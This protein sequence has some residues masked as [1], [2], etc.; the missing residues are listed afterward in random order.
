MSA[1]SLAEPTPTLMPDLP[2]NT[3]QSTFPSTGS[4]AEVSPFSSTSR[5]TATVAPPSTATPAPPQRVELGLEYLESENFVAAADQFE[6]SLVSDDLDLDLKQQALFGLGQ[7][8]LGLDQTMSAADI[9]S[10]FLAV[11][12]VQG[13]E[14]KP[15]EAEDIGLFNDGPVAAEA[16]FLLGQTFEE[17][18]DCKGAIGAYSTYLE[19]NPDMAVYVQSRIGDCQLT[20]GDRTGAV[21]AYQAAV[22]GGSLPL[23]EV[24]LRQQLA[25]MYEQDGDYP[26]A[27]EQ[28]MAIL[29]VAQNEE[30]RG[31]ATYLAGAAELAA[32]DQESGYARYQEA[33]AN[34]PKAYESYLALTALIDAGF[35]VDEFQRGMVDYNAQAYESAL[36]A[37]SRYIE[38][39]PEHREDTHLY[40]AW[41]YEELGNV[42]AAL[43]QI[44]AYIEATQPEEQATAVVGTPAAGDDTSVESLSIEDDVALGWIEK[45]KLQ[46]RAGLIEEAMD[47]YSVYV[48]MFPEGEDAAFAAWWSAA[49]AERIG[50]NVIAID[51]YKA[52]A[53]TY[54]RHED[55]PE[56]LYRAGILSWIKGDSEEAQENW[57]K[58]A[59]LYPD[60]RYGAAALL[61]LLRTM[62]EEE[63]AE[64]Y[65]QAAATRFE[66]YFALRVQHVASDTL[67]FQTAENLQLDLGE[68]EQIAAETWLR[69]RFELEPEIDLRSLSA[70][71]ASDD[72]LIR[73]QKL[74]R[75]G[76][77]EEAKRELESLRMDNVSDALAS[78]QLALFFRD[79]GLY[80]SS[81]LAATTIMKLASTDVFGVPRFIGGLAYP[82]HFADLV[83]SESDR[84]ELDPLLIFAL[85][86]QESLFE[87]FAHSSAAAQ[88]LSQVIPDTGAY[89]AQ[90]LDWPDYVNE[91]LYKPYVGIAFGAFYLDQQ[92][93]AFNGD[94]AV[95]LSAYNAGPGNAARWFGQVTDDIDLYVE[96]V[97]FSET[98]QYIERIYTGQAVYRYLYGEE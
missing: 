56:A 60:K 59:D 2:T 71:L 95:A 21:A 83:V 55:A 20:L 96:T 50:E 53:E 6:A 98:R 37:F 11:A 27:I 22:N 12:A 10:E 24:S 86:R 25:R 79:L 17:S 23:M 5:P 42:N 35:T 32:G 33:V 3:P 14:E 62:P 46:A 67:P 57:R 63:L 80:R 44:D 61:W 39:N 29:N 82:T 52:L 74:W 72:R 66:D 90:R 77:R 88:G 13:E 91:D 58:A 40:M 49:L 87:S 16:Y 19:A 15:E 31:R 7:A 94:A 41:S 1:T 9:L 18:G 69:D 75:L 38:A 4:E 97:D 26:S 51:R 48:D 43:A 92:L 54:A 8:K 84:Y 85:I 47:S 70:D 36:A 65:A 45:A 68:E 28:Y 30:I 89:I 73:G 81:I 64:E 78:Y 93:D 34:Y 76:L